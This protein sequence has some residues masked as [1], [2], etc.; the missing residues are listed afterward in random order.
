M[1]V[2]TERGCSGVNPPVLMPTIPSTATSPMPASRRAARCSSALIRCASIDV[3]VA[4]DSAAAAAVQVRSAGPCTAWTC[5]PVQLSASRRAAATA[6]MSRGSTQAI[7]SS[8]GRMVVSRP[9]RSPSTSMS[10]L[11]MK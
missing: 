6:A 9:A 1:V 3:P 10:R 11:V 2:S 8:S 7:G 5:R 4:V